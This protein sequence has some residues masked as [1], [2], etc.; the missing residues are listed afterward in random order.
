MGFHD[1]EEVNNNFIFNSSVYN[2]ILLKIYI[3]KKPSIEYI[4]R[5]KYILRVEYKSKNFTSFLKSLCPIRD[6]FPCEID[7][8]MV[9]IMNTKGITFEDTELEDVQCVSHFEG[10]LPYFDG[11]ENIMFKLVEK[12][13]EWKL[14]NEEVNLMKK[15]IKI[16]NKQICSVKTQDYF[17][18]VLGSGK[19]QKVYYQWVKDLK[20]LNLEPYQQFGYARCNGNMYLSFAFAYDKEKKKL[21]CSSTI[22]QNAITYFTKI[23]PSNLFIQEVDNISFYCLKKKE[24]DYPKKDT[25]YFNLSDDIGDIEYKEYK[26]PKYIIDK[27]KKDCELWR[28]GTTDFNK[29]MHISI[30][31]NMDWVKDLMLIGLEKAFTP[32]AFSHRDKTII[33]LVLGY[34]REEKELHLVK[35]DGYNLTLQNIEDKNLFE[36]NFS[37]VEEIEI[38]FPRKEKIFVIQ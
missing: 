29:T 35:E 20:L 32:V 36:Q 15:D 19:E 18:I 5:F 6:E 33:A 31:V 3:S 4:Q 28:R 8:G 12:Y 23:E 25:I 10:Y 14:A 34:N 30:N 1:Q 21:L 26:N 9:L 13:D 24:I 17:T 37:K 27:I 2:E 38:E 16:Y 7:I 22:T 11:L